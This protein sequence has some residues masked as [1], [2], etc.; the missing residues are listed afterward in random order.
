MSAISSSSPVNVVVVG[1]GLAGK[2]FHCY[3]VSLTPGLKLYGVVARSASTKEQVTK[4]YPAVKIYSSLDE[5]CADS[6]VQVIVLATLP[7]DH[8]AQ[9]VQVLASGKHVVVDKPMCLSLEECDAMIAASEKSGKLLTI[10]QNRRWDGDFMTIQKLMSEGALGSVKWVETSLNKPFSDKAWKAAPM[11]EGGGRF[12]DLGV[13]LIDQ[14]LFLFK[15]KTV[16]SVFA[17]ILFE[18]KEQPGV[19]SH[20]L[21]TITFHDGTS[22]VVDTSSMN[23]YAKPRF[24]VVG[25]KATYW[26]KAYAADDPH[27]AWMKKGDI[28]RGYDDQDEY[29]FLRNFNG[30]NETRVPTVHGRWRNYYENLSD[31]LHGKGAKLAVTPLSV[32]RVLS[33]IDAAILSS[34]TDQAV[35][36]NLPPVD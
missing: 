12:L 3:L 31:V 10:F 36:V 15:E 24:V 26:K 16:K 34:K 29:G 33:V 1:Y 22:V 32:R 14:A 13:H 30:S 19:D 23:P 9:A 27:E 4:D 18:N 35:Q 7:G 2:S 8:K 5:A 20:S 25:D 11:S 17:R 28:D 21:V 6:A